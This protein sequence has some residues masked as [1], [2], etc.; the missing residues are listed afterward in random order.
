MQFPILHYFAFLI[1][2]FQSSPTYDKF[3]FFFF[4]ETAPP[5]IYP[6]P[7]HDALPTSPPRQR[8]DAREPRLDRARDVVARAARDGIMELA[9][10]HRTPRELERRP[11]VAP[12]RP[13]RQRGE[14]LGQARERE[15]GRGIAPLERRARPVHALERPRVAIGR[16]QLSGKGRRF[17]AVRGG[18]KEFIEP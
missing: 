2:T 12:S 3:S 4:N 8:L 15:L 17:R 13:P 11:P 6:L 7:L 9:S 18:L 5:E 10:H 14:W 1:S 16:A